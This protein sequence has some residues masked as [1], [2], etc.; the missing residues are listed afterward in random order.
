MNMGNGSTA[1]RR[2]PLQV[3]KLDDAKA[4]A[5]RKRTERRELVLPR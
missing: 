3:E 1:L 4:E 5:E 2:I